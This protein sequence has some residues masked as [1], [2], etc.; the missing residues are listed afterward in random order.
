VELLTLIYGTRALILTR[1]L[2][3]KTPL[4]LEKNTIRKL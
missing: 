1:T 4:S 3:D 2:K